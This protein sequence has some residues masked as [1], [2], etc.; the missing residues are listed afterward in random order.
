MTTRP[1]GTE[2]YDGLP[3]N[4]DSLRIVSLRVAGGRW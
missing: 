2:S 1:S 4:A 3:R